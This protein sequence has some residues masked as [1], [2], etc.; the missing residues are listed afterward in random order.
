MEFIF[1]KYCLPDDLEDYGF[2]SISRHNGSKVEAVLPA[3][4]LAD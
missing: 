2:A 4:D 3:D 1:L